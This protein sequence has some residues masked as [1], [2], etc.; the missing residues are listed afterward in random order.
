MKKKISYILVIT[1]FLI[2][3][4]SGWLYYFWNVQLWSA[5]P[6]I[7]RLK[8]IYSQDLEL[9]ILTIVNSTL[10]IISLIKV[11]TL[12]NKKNLKQMAKQN[13]PATDDNIINTPENNWS[14]LY[15]NK[16]RNKK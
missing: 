1:I 4:I 6:S 8:Y 7:S 11:L 10:Y 12:K 14:K 16:T 2:L 9:K 15:D 13:T 5:I 3:P